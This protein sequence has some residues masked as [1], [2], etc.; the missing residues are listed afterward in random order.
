MNTYRYKVDFS[1]VKHFIE[2]HEVLKRDLDFPDYYGG[3]LDA[4]WDCI[5]DQ[6]LSGI[7]YIEIFNIKHIAKFSNYDVKLKDVFKEAK[8]AY[9]G[10]YSDNFFV[11]IVRE[12]GT[13]EEIT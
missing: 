9:N 11:T 10:K 7:T 1:D 8:H 3:N 12:D 2:I 4:L 5:T 6:L 13:R